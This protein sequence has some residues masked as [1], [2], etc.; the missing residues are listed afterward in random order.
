MPA[1]LHSRRWRAG[2][3]RITGEQAALRRVATQVARAAAPEEVLSAATSRSTARPAQ[4]PPWRSACPS[5]T[6]AGRSCYPEPRRIRPHLIET[7]LDYKRSSETDAIR[8]RPD[9]HEN[10]ASGLR[11]LARRLQFA[12]NPLHTVITG[13]GN[14][15]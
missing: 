4:A 6:P 9:P 5:S 3:D 12:H 15:C 7:W 10:A 1:R 8:L 13:V 11:H 2:D 14:D